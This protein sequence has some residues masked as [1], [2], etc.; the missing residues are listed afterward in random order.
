[1]HKSQVD[2]CD[3]LFLRRTSIETE[4]KTIFSAINK[5]RLRI[6]LRTS[7]KHE[8]VREISKRISG[9]SR[10]RKKISICNAR[11]SRGVATRASNRSSLVYFVY[12]AIIVQCDGINFC[13]DCVVIEDYAV[14]SCLTLEYKRRSTETFVTSATC[15]TLERDSAMRNAYAN[16]TSVID[17]DGGSTRSHLPSFHIFQRSRST[18]P[19]RNLGQAAAIDDVFVRQ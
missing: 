9:A 13:A 7:S 10:R 14:F 1:M 3:Y 16:Q 15:I 8:K 12:F 17:D 18:G 4:K 6:S 11:G 19:L 2:T 5:K